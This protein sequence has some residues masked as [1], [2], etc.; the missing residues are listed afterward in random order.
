MTHNIRP[1]RP[2][3]RLGAAVALWLAINIGIDLVSVG[4]AA[5]DLNLLLTL[6][7]DTPLDEWGIFPDPGGISTWTGLARGVLFA[8]YLVAAILAL[9]WMYRA[10]LN[11]HAF[12]R[13]LESKPRGAVFWYFVPIALLWKPFEAM[14]ETWRVSENPDRWK[15][16]ST[17]GLLRWWWGFWLSGLITGNVSSRL[18]WMADETGLLRAA[19]AL[20]LLSSLCMIGS[21][22]LLI[23]IV[24]EVTARQTA[25]I[26]EGRSRAAPTAEIQPSPESGGA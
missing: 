12:A 20:E 2:I 11:A 5:I 19:H 4:L 25:L 22:L 23:R 14:N 9:K 3:E 1:A 7:V 18:L 10:N 16:V 6:P 21:G 24:R 17:P 13:G 15:F 26:G 8:G